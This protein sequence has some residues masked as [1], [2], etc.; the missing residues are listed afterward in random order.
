MRKKIGD[1][2][3]AKRIKDISGVYKM[4]MCISPLRC[5]SD[6]YINEKV[7]VTNL[8]EYVKEKK[9]NDAEFTFFHAFN[10]ALCKL[11]YHKPLLNRYIIN[12]KVYERND[13]TVGFIAKAAFE[14]TAKATVNV[15]TVNKNDT[16]TEIKKKFSTRVKEV[17]DINNNSDNGT[18]DTLSFLQ[19]LPQWLV[20]IIA[21]F[22][23]KFDKHDWLPRSMT[24]NDIYHSSVIVTNLG[25]IKCGAIYHN[26]IDFGTNSMLIAIGEVKKEPVVNEMGEIIVRDVCEF[27]ITCDCRIADGFYFA[28]AVN[29]FKDIVNNPN[30]LDTPINEDINIK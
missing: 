28:G 16:I 7:D 24:N 3:D 27:G 23:I 9:E 10:A 2:K 20:N 29:L 15:I 12:R 1:R 22:I 30:I 19:K 18:D 8:V 14:E 26:I 25:S 5:D 6:I 11:I 13:I 21:W 17:R 4:L